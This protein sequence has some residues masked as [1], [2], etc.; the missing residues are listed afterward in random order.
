MKT[1]DLVDLTDVRALARMGV[2]RSVRLAA[3]LSLAEV[4]EA[5]GVVPVTVYRWE[6]GERSPRGEAALRYKS[7]LD[8]LSKRRP[9]RREA[10]K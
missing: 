7:L 5:V 4:A 9:A 2:A 8:E 1:E 6:T 3:G 10:V